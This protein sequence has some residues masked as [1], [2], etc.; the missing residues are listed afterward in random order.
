MRNRNA[1]PRVSLPMRLLAF[2]LLAACT[3]TPCP[4]PRAPDVRVHASA[5]AWHDLLARLPGRWRAELDD[6]RTIEIEL[7]PIANG[8]ALLE[9]F[10]A[11]PAH[12]TASV[13]HPDGDRLRLTHYCGQGNQAYLVLVEAND[14]RLRFA[15]EHEGN[16]GEGAVMVAAE[17]AWE[18]GGFARTETYRDQRGEETTETMHFRR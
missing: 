3:R 10:G 2:L 16:E 6:G 7:R 1:G 15:L 4:S 18:N 8:S 12:Q 13:I 9:L 17:L 11:D 14:D 5:Q